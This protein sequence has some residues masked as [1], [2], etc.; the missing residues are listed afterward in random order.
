MC[1]LQAILER[2]SHKIEELHLDGNSITDAG[3]KALQRER[4][5]E[6]NN[7]HGP[8]SLSPC[9]KHLRS[10]WL[11]LWQ[12]VKEQLQLMRGLKFIG[13]GWTLIGNEAAKASGVVWWWSD[14]WWSVRRSEPAR[15]S[16]KLL[17]NRKTCRCPWAA[18]RLVQKGWR[19]RAFWAIERL[20][21]SRAITCLKCFS[22]ALDA[23][24]PGG[25]LDVEEN[26]EWR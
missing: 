6:A 24:V 5:N 4:Q 22:Q 19:C 14:W 21:R 3:I 1:C 20:L 8:C 15:C 7:S 2:T 9:Q 13:F 11:C 17:G 18:T 10:I 26:E 12:D 16:Q 25:A 23:E